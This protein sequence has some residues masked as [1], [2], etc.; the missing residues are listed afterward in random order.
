MIETQETVTP[1]YPSRI[2]EVSKEAKNAERLLE[3]HPL[4][5]N[6]L[7]DP[8]KMFVFPPHSHIVLDF[9]EEYAGGIRILV[10]ALEGVSAGANPLRIRFG[11]SVGE[12]MVNIG[13]KNATGDH[14]PRDFVYALPP[15]CD[16]T[17]G[18]SGFRFAR[19]DNVGEKTMYLQA[20]VLMA[21]HPNVSR[22][23][24]FRSDDPR[25][26]RIFKISCR[27]AFLCLQ[28][29]Y[30]YD[31]IKRDRL[32]WTGDMGVEVKTILDGYGALDGVHR[33]L[34][35]SRDASPLPGWMNGIPS[36]SL[37]WI[38]ELEDYYRRTAEL[39]WLKTNARY[40]QGLVH[41]LSLCVDEEGRL[42]FDRCA[43]AAHSELEYFI[44]WPTWG[45]ENSETA[46]VALLKIA[47]RSA[48]YLYSVLGLNTDAVSS[49]AQRVREVPLTKKAMKSQIGTVYEGYG[50]GDLDALVKDGGHGFSTFSMYLCLKA[51]AD[52][53]RIEDAL[54]CLKEYYGGMLDHGATTFFEDYD[55]DWKGIG[56]DQM[57]EE[58]KPYLASDYGN[59]CYVGY[60]LSLCHGWAS[61]PAPF[62]LEEVAGIHPLDAY[63]YE[64]APKLGP[65]QT[66]DATIATVL[67]PLT[68]HC[69]EGK[70]V[71][72]EK[73]DGIAVSVRVA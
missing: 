72:Y 33:S 17:V 64:I 24:H 20:I 47:L 13:E 52:G 2:V 30:L 40:L 34:D 14:S 66:L 57:P 3:I 6:L 46:V 42:N 7:S 8:L 22:V 67:G 39:D 5:L 15:L 65:I 32:V 50:R 28:N 10:K 19:L 35:F 9:G 68:I 48:T 21:K 41:Q 59:Y 53:N 56:V 69:R 11:E 73:P 4:V 29:G 26:N 36:Y 27:T 31:G 12:T 49:L 54:R 25:L 45:N 1:I 38:M 70:L 44:D 16:N 62:L 71:S 37:W 58:G 51:L 18:C 55:L 61:G 60:R 43:D 23:A 63:H